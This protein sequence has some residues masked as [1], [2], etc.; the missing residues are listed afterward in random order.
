MLDSIFPKRLDNHYRGHWLALVL[1]GLI[2]LMRLAMSLNSAFNAHAVA[3][4]ADGL[5]IDT[6][7]P[8][9]ALTVLRI[10]AL[11]GFA[12]LLGALLAIVALVRY[13]A[14]VPLVFLLLLADALGRRGVAML[15]AGEPSGGPTPIGFYINLGILAALVLGFV[16]SVL[17]IR[18]RE[19]AD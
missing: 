12:G 2:V 13:R 1:L 9:M 3:T 8:D 4:G 15:Y 18:P 6:L 14:M 11:L 16:L 17:P 10:F 7:A 19:T 5:A